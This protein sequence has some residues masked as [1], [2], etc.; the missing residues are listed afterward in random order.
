MR[1]TA[2]SWVAKAEEVV[3]MLDTVCLQPKVQGIITPYWEVNIWSFSS[4]YS[5]FYIDHNS[6]FLN[7]DTVNDNSLILDL[8]DPANSDDDATKD[9]RCQDYVFSRLLG[10]L[11]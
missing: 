4:F 3:N 7:W 2:S 11:W 8:L 6:P 10:Q 1:T 5:A 9:G